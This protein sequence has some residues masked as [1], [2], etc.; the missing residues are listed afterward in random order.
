MGSNYKKKRQN[1][2]DI[3]VKV[4]KEKNLKFKEFKKKIIE[5]Q[6]T[7]LEGPE[8]PRLFY[9]K[10]NIFMLINEIDDIKNIHVKD[11]M[12]LSTIDIDTLE[13]DAQ[14]QRYV[15]YCQ[16]ILRKIGDHSHTKIKCIYFMI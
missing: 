15:N 2:I 10:N 3:D 9:Y 13:Y 1:I 14:K 7:I 8:D 12:Y 11:A 16:Q 6:K 4:L 5:H